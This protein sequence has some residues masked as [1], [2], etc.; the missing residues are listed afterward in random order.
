MTTE[1][2]SRIMRAVKSR[3]TGPE[4]IVR[5]LAHRLGYRYR[6]HRSDLPGKPDLTF[7]RR[8]A[9]IL[10]NGCFWHGHD[11]NRGARSPK[12]NIDYWTAK[13]RR[14]VARDEENLGRLAAS[15]WR[16][17]VVWECEIKATDQLAARLRG[18]LDGATP[19][20]D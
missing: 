6:L 4:K 1:D 9:V 15:G 8:R 3:D 19:R 13:I 7:P 5:Q 2:R 14:N 17:L 20:N 12:T 10:V 16:A 11:C 18:F